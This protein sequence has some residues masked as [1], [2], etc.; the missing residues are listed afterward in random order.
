MFGIH[1]N[2]ILVE[3]GIGNEQNIG[4]RWTEVVEGGEIGRTA[5]MLEMYK[6]RTE[7]NSKQLNKTLMEMVRCSPARG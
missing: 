1:H 2:V 3:L 5:M 6:P 7:R 4:E